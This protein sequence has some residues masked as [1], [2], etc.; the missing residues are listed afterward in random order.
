MLKGAQTGTV[1]NVGVSVKGFDNVIEATA[2]IENRLKDLSPIMPT[3]GIYLVSSI[4]GRIKAG[5]KP[6]NSAVTQAYK[7]NNLPL[8]DTGQYFASFTWQHAGKNRIKVGTPKKQARILNDGGKITPKKAKMLYIPAGAFTRQI[9][10]KSNAS[11]SAESSVRAVIDWLENNGY[12]VWW[13]KNV[14]MCKKGKKGKETP[15]YY[16]KKQVTI[17]AR[18]HIYVSQEDRIFILRK[19]YDYAFK[20]K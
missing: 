3:I 9:E 11:T 17:P 14:V 6:D 10:R 15:V 2:K 16:L 1:I 18:P 5:L 13:A 7:K 4:Q 12:Q 8:R 20:G 19:V